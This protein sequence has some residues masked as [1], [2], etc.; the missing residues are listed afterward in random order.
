M[1]STRDLTTLPDIE[2][3]R[4]RLQQMAA[5]ESVFANEYGVSQ[6]EFHPNWDHSEQMGAFKN[7]SGDEV[8][9]H[10][11][12]SGCIII[13]FAHESKM[14]PYRT[15]P[16][17]L[18]PGLLSGVPLE[19]KASLDEPAF[20]I[21]STT[22]VIWRL[23]TDNE[24]RTATIEYSNDEYGDGSH[25]LLSHL[26]YTAAEFAEWLADNYEVEV[27][28]GIVSSVF[29]N[30][31]LTDQQLSTLIPDATTNQLREAVS[32]TGYGLAE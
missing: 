28:S 23:A 7:G 18:W 12:H 9:A 22:F 21:A 30:N 14:S 11:T 13:G 15:S 1:L 31:P 17:E 29:S 2:S 26:I 8:F 3:L 19:F 6:Y 16:P 10:F 20:D 25:E 5:L 24:W 27:D 4:Q 32:E